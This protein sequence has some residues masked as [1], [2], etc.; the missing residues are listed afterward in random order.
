M[1]SCKILPIFTQEPGN[2][3]RR[4]AHFRKALIEKIYSKSSK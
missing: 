4:E 1:N 2:L 3:K